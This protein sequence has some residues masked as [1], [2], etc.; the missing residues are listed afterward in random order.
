VTPKHLPAPVRGQA[1]YR[2][3]ERLDQVAIAQRQHQAKVYRATKVVDT[4]ASPVP[5]R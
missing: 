3:S 1:L 5:A 2:G 4:C